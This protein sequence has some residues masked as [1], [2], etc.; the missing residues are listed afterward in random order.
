MKKADVQ[1]GGTYRAK[2]SGRVVPVAIVRESPY[3]GWDGVNTMTGHAVRIKSA[4]RLRGSTE[5]LTIAEANRLAKGKARVSED[6]TSPGLWRIEDDGR[7]QV[8]EPMTKAGWLG[9]LHG[10]WMDGD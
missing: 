6:P 1:I 5:L 9:F 8:H 2:V 4:Q 3:G 10:Y 7:A